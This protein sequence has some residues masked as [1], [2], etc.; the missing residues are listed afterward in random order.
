M[1]KT[2]PQMSPIPPNTRFCKLL[3]WPISAAWIACSDPDD[4]PVPVPPD[5]STTAV[6]TTSN[7]ATGTGGFS[8]TTGNSAPDQGGATREAIGGAAGV[9]SVSAATGFGGVLPLMQA[10]VRH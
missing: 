2:L 4:P 6:P 8:T 3:A 7:T 10:P 9:S 1:Q 5:E